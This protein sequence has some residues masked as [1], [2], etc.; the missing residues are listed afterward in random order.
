MALTETE[1]KDIAAAAAQAAVAATAA[2]AGTADARTTA[3]T[4]HSDRTRATTRDSADRS[5]TDSFGAEQIDSDVNA[6][7]AMQEQVVADK[8]RN[9][10]WFDMVIGQVYRHVEDAHRQHQDGIEH[11]RSMRMK[12]FDNMFG[13]RDELEVLAL[14]VAEG[15]VPKVIEIAGKTE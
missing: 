10:T 6:E 2:A 8:G 1:I 9:R 15:L 4:E 7:E 12:A 11:Y 3:N 5:R 13:Q 14:K